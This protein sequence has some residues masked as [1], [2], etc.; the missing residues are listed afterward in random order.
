MLIC[1]NS[2]VNLGRFDKSECMSLL[3]S[4]VFLI[5]RGNTR[6]TKGTA[7]VIY[8]DIYDAK[9]ACDKLNGFSFDKRYLVVL[10]YSQTKQTKKL[11]Q[12]RLEAEN[13]KLR[14]TYLKGIAN[15]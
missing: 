15:K 1:T 8:E 5:F 13:E 11:D 2:L 7:F 14:A 4:P 12:R 9:S 3:L 6:E 10:Y